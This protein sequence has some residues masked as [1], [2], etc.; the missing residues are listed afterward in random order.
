MKCWREVTHI[1][2]T[3]GERQGKV[4]ALT[5]S[6]GHMAFRRIPRVRLHTLTAFSRTEAPEKCHCPHC[7][8]LPDSETPNRR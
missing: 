4:W 7:A 8:N 3:T 6:C 5:L 2:I 1:E